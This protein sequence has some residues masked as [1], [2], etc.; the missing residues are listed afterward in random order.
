ML[1]TCDFYPIDIETTQSKTNK[2]K[3]KAHLLGEVICNNLG[4]GVHTFNPNTH[5]SQCIWNSEFE[6]NLVYRVS[7]R[8]V[9]ATQRKTLYQKAN[10][11]A[12]IFYLYIQEPLLQ[13]LQLS[14]EPQYTPNSPE[15]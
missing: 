5:E 11:T 12:K 14:S 4:M 15:L 9:R 7:S 6:A 3:K 10:T 1:K 13:V 8:T 2:P